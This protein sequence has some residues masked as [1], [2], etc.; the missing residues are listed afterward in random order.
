MHIPLLYLQIFC[1][2]VAVKFIAGVS[3]MCPNVGPMPPRLA[4]NDHKTEFLFDHHLT[5]VSP[6]TDNEYRLTAI[7]RRWFPVATAI[8]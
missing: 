7:D 1:S 6:Q 3:V 8:V 5:T 2:I 4:I